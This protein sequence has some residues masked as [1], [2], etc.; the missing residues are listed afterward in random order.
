MSLA[1][2]VVTAF[3]SAGRQPDP[4]P[5]PAE[6]PHHRRSSPIIASLVIVTDQVL[7][8]F[9]FDISKQ[10]SVFVG[11][12]ITNCIVMGRAEA[13]AMQQW[14]LALASSTGSAT[15]SATGC[16][17]MSVAFVRELLGA[18]TLFGFSVMPLV[19]EGGWYVPNGLML[20]APRRLLP[21]RLLHLGPAHAGSPS[22][23]RK[24]SDV[25]ALPESGH[26]VPSSSRTWPWPSSWACAPCLAVSK[27]VETAIG[28]GV[29][30]I[31][32]LAVTTPL[33]KLLNEHLL[34]EG[35]LAWVGL[36]LR[37]RPQ[38]PHLP[39]LIGTIAAAVQMVEMALDRF[40]PDALQRRSAVFLPL[41]AV[42]CAIL[43]APSSWWS[44]TTPWARATSSASAPASAGR[45]R[46]SR[47]PPSARS[48]ATATCPGPLRGLGITFIMV[49]LMAMGFMA[50]SGIQL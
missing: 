20:I 28:L 13:F 14:P 38:L 2:T 43:G 22:R 49:G 25:G 21:D 12:I 42:N 48:S 37:R 24:T 41:I 8:A 11:L 40:S 36:E 23:W 44:A 17:L 5:D 47:W 45:W 4:Q 9:V 1:V 16:V 3:S 29:A 46:S 19:T 10:L 31:F 30:V 6:H 32:V 7:Q 39:E 15:A 35:A 27:K 50:F 18:G 34:K 33:N 26:E